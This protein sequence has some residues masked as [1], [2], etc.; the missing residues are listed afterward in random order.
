MKTEFEQEYELNFGEEE[1][2]VEGSVLP[3]I[4]GNHPGGLCRKNR[5]ILVFYRQSGRPNQS[6]RCVHGNAFQDL[7]G[8]GRSRFQI[9]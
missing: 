7:P 8:A 6:M 4:E 5:T 2:R 3:K 9:I 1:I